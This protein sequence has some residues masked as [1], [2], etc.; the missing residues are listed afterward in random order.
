MTSTSPYADSLTPRP[1]ASQ[2]TA[3]RRD[4]FLPVTWWAGR[5][6]VCPDMLP[7]QAAGND[8]VNGQEAGFLAAILTGIIVPAQ[9]FSL[10]QIDLQARPFNHITKFDDRRDFKFV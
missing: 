8:M 10:G 3:A 7:A 2:H 4:G 5:N 1:I 9:D 6:H